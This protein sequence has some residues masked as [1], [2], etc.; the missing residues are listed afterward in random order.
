MLKGIRRAMEINRGIILPP[1]LPLPPPSLV[2]ALTLALVL[3][4]G[5]VWRLHNHQHHQQ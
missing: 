5:G 4:R 1:P 3:V 2:L